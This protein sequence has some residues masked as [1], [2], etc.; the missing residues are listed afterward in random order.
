[1]HKTVSNTLNLRFKINRDLLGL[2]IGKVKAVL[3][4]FSSRSGNSHLQLGPRLPD[5]ALFDFLK[6]ACNTLIG[7][8]EVLFFDVFGLGITLIIIVV[9]IS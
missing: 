2:F 5:D 7:S 8:C 3:A 4:V 9:A 6:S 1:M